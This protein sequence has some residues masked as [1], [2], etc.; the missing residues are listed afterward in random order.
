VLPL[1]E[2]D[3]KRF[4]DIKKRVGDRLKEQMAAASESK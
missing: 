1:T 4:T 3:K 2:E